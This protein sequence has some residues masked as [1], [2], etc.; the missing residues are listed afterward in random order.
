MTTGKREE[1]EQVLKGEP[2]AGSAFTERHKQSVLQRIP[3]TKPIQGQ[4]DVEPPS[5]KSMEKL[6]LPGQRKSHKKGWVVAITAAAAVAGI[7]LWNGQYM[8]PVVERLYPASALLLA[9]DAN[10]ELLTEPMKRTMA[11]TMR[12]YLGKQLEVTTVRDDTTFPNVSNTIYV[13]AG[14]NTDDNYAEFSLDAATGELQSW[15]L[16]GLMDVSKLE[17]RYLSQVPALL[18]SIGSDGTLKPLQ[19]D[20]SAHMFSSDDDE[21]PEVMTT[22]KLGNENGKVEGSIIWKQDEVIYVSGSIDLGRAPKEA[23]DRAKQVVKAYSGYSA[24]ALTSIVYN[25]NMQDHWSKWDLTFGERYLV[26]LSDGKY[27]NDDEVS[28]YDKAL[29]PAFNSDAREEAKTDQG[30]QRLMYV[31]ES[32]MREAADPI[33]KNMFHAPLEQYSFSPDSDHPGQGTFKLEQGNQVVDVLRISYDADGRII[34][35]SR[36]RE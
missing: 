20:R 19:V 10:K 16:R 6:N 15:T 30:K 8:D 35:L 1:L 34:S 36:S 14:Q 22:V 4:S 11:I 2:F 17:P 28:V 31:P 9:D 12:D 3:E 13:Q 5:T 26:T 29:H 27:G 25:K 7:L 32:T 18:K 24:F 21:Q 23:V 33:I